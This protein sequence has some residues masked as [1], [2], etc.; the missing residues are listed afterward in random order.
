MRSVWI[1]Q[2][3]ATWRSSGCEFWRHWRGKVLARSPSRSGGAEGGGSLIFR[4]LHIG[5]SVPY[6]AM[7]T[8]DSR[9]P[10]GRR[11]AILGGCALHWQGATGVLL[12][13]KEALP[14][15]PPKRRKTH[16]HPQRPARA[17]FRRMKLRPTDRQSFIQENEAL[18][19]SFIQENEALPHRPAELHSGE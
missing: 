19:Q 8:K 3:P 2:G 9:V 4:A 18:P 17:S 7:A 1:T 14:H 11:I 16:P 12:L 10:C 5:F 13:E 6:G 15:R